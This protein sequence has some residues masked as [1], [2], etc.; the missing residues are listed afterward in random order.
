ME[1][2][3][4]DDHETATGTARQTQHLRRRVRGN[5][6]ESSNHKE[7]EGV[8][9]DE[10]GG[11]GVILWYLHRCCKQCL[12]K[13]QGRR[14]RRQEEAIEGG[15]DQGGEEQEGVAHKDFPSVQPQVAV[16]SEDS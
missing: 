13:L 5:R 10:G 9:E 3:E 1:A 7:V 16:N 4:E 11:E 15:E 6:V 8:D 2:H 14:L 12:V